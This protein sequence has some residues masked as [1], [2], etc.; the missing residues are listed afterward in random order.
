MPAIKKLV[1]KGFKSFAKRTELDFNSN[2][3]VVL[4]PNGSG[5]SNVT[6]AICFALGTSSA[7]TLRAES[8]AKLIY[9]GGEKGSPAKEAEVS[10]VFANEGKAFP[11]EGEEFTVS[12]IL[13][14]NGQSTYKLN[15]KTVTRQQILDLLAAGRINPDGHNI[16]LQGE[17]TH[18]SEMRPNERRQIIEEI[19]G[20]SVYE[21]KKT[22]ALLELQHVQ[23]KLNEAEI[24][25]A[26]RQ[27]TLNELKADRDSAMQ[28]RE[29]EDVLTRNKATRVSLQINEMNEKKEK[30]EKSK[31]GIQKEVDKLKLDIEDMKK[32]VEAKK[33]RIKEIISHIEERSGVEQKDISGKVENSKGEIARKQARKEVCEGEVGKLTQRK[34]SL[35]SEIKAIEGQIK[36]FEGKKQL[37][38]NRIGI[39][40]SDEKSIQ[41]KIDA[42]KKKHGVS[43]AE[44]CGK[45]IAEIE[46][47]EEGLNKTA[48]E[49][50]QKKMDA[51]RKKEVA[52]IE[53]NGVNAKIKEIEDEI[54]KD[55]EKFAQ[56]KLKREEFKNVT[57][58]LAK[59]LNE[60]SVFASQLADARKEYDE[61]NEKLAKLKARAIG[62]RENAAA[63]IALQKIREAK[64]DGVI[65]L[66][67]ELG[68]VSS[69]YALAL[70]VA[71]AQRMK[72]VVVNTDSTAAKCISYLRENKL[73]IVTFLPMNKIQEALVEQEAEKA[74]K[75]KGV[76]GFAASLVSFEPKYKNIFRYVFGS[77]LIVEDMATARRIGIG[78]A[79]MAT[80]E[81]DIAERSGAMTGGFRMRKTGMGFRE[82]E[83]EH[84]LE[85]SEKDAGSLVQM[86]NMLEEKKTK[87]EEEI[88]QLRERKVALETELKLAGDSE[89]VSSD[90]KKLNEQKDGFEKQLQEFLKEFEESGKSLLAVNESVEKLK[91]EKNAL[92][93]KVTKAGKASMEELSA[94]EDELRLAKENKMKE[95]GG[96]ETVDMQIGIQKQELQKVKDIIGQNERAKEGFYSEIKQLAEELS[97]EKD[98]LKELES[99]QRKVA[100]EFQ[101]MFKE[102]D[103]LKDKVAAIEGRIIGKEENLRHR[104][105][106]EN[107]FSVK[108][109]EILGGVAG[110]E[111]EFEQYASVQLRRGLTIEQLNTEVSAIERELKAMGNINMRALEVYEKANEECKNLLEK[112]EKLKLEKEDVLNMMLSIE[113]KKKGAFME[114]FDKLKGNFQKIFASLSTKGEVNLV[115]E[116]AENP[117]EGG[118]DITVRVGS[119]KFVD[120]IGFSGG[121]KTLAAL[122]FLFAIQEFNPAPFYVMDEVDAALDK[123]NSD[124]LS[125]LL[126]AYSGKSQYIVISHNDGVISAADSV[127]GV[128]L[129]KD[130]HGMSK[131]VSLKI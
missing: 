65:G 115:I 73:G 113:E 29:K 18:F 107:E 112:H 36:E 118:I 78:R 8:S 53:L 63:D 33:A 57:Q 79:R 127:Y 21:D 13:K 69:K 68:T 116:N 52:Q 66:V 91:T 40:D 16:I 23:E 84:D 72:S 124:M 17:I 108:I 102:K 106:K 81:G 101:K 96:S 30:A 77:T 58:K 90:L 3:A 45:R 130:G 43:D 126:A 41:Q 54:H 5:K 26:E 95:Q 109:A 111:K 122:A 1:M 71:A 128:S 100:S 103:E 4:G 74:A 67:S 22:K 131:V 38:A 125:R 121:E 37:A 28:F 27:K 117:F 119:N 120:I 70:E 93:E 85:N 88:S 99:T 110:L 59:A 87:N 76:I 35:E 92:R 49:L 83:L 24:I 9:H 55:K 60:N 105:E 31:A 19:A 98:S 61:E 47:E 44:E 86:V 89:E 34:K 39:F 20:I 80:L 6:D 32:E 64:I 75:E 46:A 51:Q 10:I 25:L 12:R 123:M 94:L 14:H 56:L 97:K 82:K 2:F 48:F 62:I 42:W 129:P 11:F 114:V 50:N 15:G 7:K 104:E